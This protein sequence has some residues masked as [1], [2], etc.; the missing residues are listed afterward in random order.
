MSVPAP[1]PVPRPR[2]PAWRPVSAALPALL[3]LALL[4]ACGEAPEP[5]VAELPATTAIP[6]GVEDGP[7]PATE[8]ETGRMA[9]RTFPLAPLHDSG[10]RGEVIA[11]VATD[12]VVLI[13]EAEG[14]PGE[15]L[16]P[17]HVHR[18]A[19]EADGEEAVPLDPIPGLADGTGMS[20]T[21]LEPEELDRNTRWSVRVH[22]DG[23]E[24]LAC[25]DLDLPEPPGRPDA[26]ADTLP[27][28]DAEPEPLAAESAGGP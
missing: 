7:V 27:R 12:A 16:H 1:V 4:A 14:L 11:M 24:V 22:A 15:A 3:L 25:S 23:G 10:V 9:Q 6:M 5:D 13:V 2:T 8:G 18:D 26:G 19:C 28:P 21:T 20:T 17:V